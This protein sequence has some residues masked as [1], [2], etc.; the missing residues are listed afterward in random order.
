MGISTTPNNQKTLTKTTN[1]DF[2]GE[3]R[4]GFVQISITKQK[5][6]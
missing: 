5:L 3:G 4:G 2:E 6:F 1:G